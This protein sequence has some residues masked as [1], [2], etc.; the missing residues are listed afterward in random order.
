MLLAGGAAPYRL[1]SNH[2]ECMVDGLAHAFYMSQHHAKGKLSSFV[3][4]QAW[5]P[6]QVLAVHSSHSAWL[7]LYLFSTSHGLL[8]H[9]DHHLDKLQRDGTL[10]LEVELPPAVQ[11]CCQ[12]LLHQWLEPNLQVKKRTVALVFHRLETLKD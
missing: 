1:G 10:M 3:R 8:A 12:Q 4:C 5:D 7:L 11:R 2:T 6:N 9:V